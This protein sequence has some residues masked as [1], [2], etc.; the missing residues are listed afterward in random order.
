[1]GLTATAVDKYGISVA[2]SSYTTLASP[3]SS[4]M[5][6]EWQLALGGISHL[7]P[8]FTTTIDD[9]EKLLARSTVKT[10]LARVA[11]ITSTEASSPKPMS[12]GSLWENTTSTTWAPI[13][14]GTFTH[15]PVD[16]AFAF[17]FA[18]AVANDAETPTPS[19]TALPW[20]W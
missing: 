1:M 7:G 19:T 11:S 10:P 12:P 17:A 9:V 18:F 5:N 20:I 15:V 6:R 4:S 2:Y 13:S 3:L 14:F 16:F 8:A